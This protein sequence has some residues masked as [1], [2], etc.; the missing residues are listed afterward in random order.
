MAVT[1]TSN[2]SVLQRVS[3]VA[4]SATRPSCISALTAR[5]RPQPATATRLES[6]T[7]QTHSGITHATAANFGMKAQD[8]AERP[9]EVP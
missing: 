9:E 5:T 7:V 8:Y 4:V 1:L 6:A 3:E 2:A